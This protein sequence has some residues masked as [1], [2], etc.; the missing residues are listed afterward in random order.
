L[1]DSVFIAAMREKVPYRVIAPL[2]T[3]AAAIVAYNLY[4]PT[5]E[6]PLPAAVT[7][8][9]YT[10]AGAMMQPYPGKWKVPDEGLVVYDWYA[11]KAEKL[12]DHYAF[13]LKGFSD[14]LLH[15]C[16]IQK[17]WA[18][19][20]RTDKY[21]SPAAVKVLSVSENKLKL[22][23]VESGPLAVWNATGVPSAKRTAF[24]DQGNGLWKADIET[25]HRDT[26]ITI[27]KIQAPSS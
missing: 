16:P 9:D 15:L 23:L 22:R 10:H 5:A 4:H 3:D 19:I 12:G 26:V 24:K 17:G 11:G 20:G 14:R 27:W 13:E 7:S 8:D 25:G 18:V 6:E 2:S 21:L 1:P